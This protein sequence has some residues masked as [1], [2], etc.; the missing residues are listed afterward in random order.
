MK[1]SANVKRVLAY[2]CGVV[3]TA[4][5]MT[6]CLEGEP[7]A[8]TASTSEQNV[9]SATD[10]VGEDIPSDEKNPPIEVSEFCFDRESG[11]YDED[12]TLMIYH[13]DSDAKIYYTTDGSTPDEGDTLYDGKGIA[14]K[15]RTP[16]KNDLSAEKGISASGD[17]YVKGKVTKANVIRAVAI[18]PDG[19]K[20]E[21]INGTFFVGIDR[22]KEYGDVPVI[23]LLTDKENLFDYEKGIYVLGKTHDQWLAENSSNKW[24]DGWQQKGNYSNRGRDWERP[25]NV[26]YITAD[27]SEGFTQD[28]GVRIMGAASRNNNQ[29]SLRLVAREDYG[30]KNVKYPVIPENMMSDGSGEVTKY[31]SFVLR[32]GGNDCDFAKIRDPILQNLVSDRAFETMQFT[33]VV[34]FID[35][36]YW[37]MYSLVE[38]YNDNYIQNNY[39]GIDNENV[40]VIKN[41]GIEDG[42][43]D[44][45]KLFDDMYSYIANNDMSDGEKYSRA[46]EMLDMQ[47]FADYC[48]FNIYIYN[49]DSF[50]K[51]NNWSMWRVRDVDQSVPYADGKWRLM[52]FD[53]D[54]S[55]GIYSEGGNTNHNSIQDAINSGNNNNFPS[56]LFTSLLANGQFKGMFIN[57]MCDLRNVNFNPSVVSDAIDELRPVYEKLVPDTFRRFGP[58]WVAD[59]WSVEEYYS[60]KIDQFESFLVGRYRDFMPIIKNTFALEDA[61]EVTVK[62]DEKDGGVVINGVTDVD[63]GYDFEG[64]YFKEYPITIKAVCTDGKSFVRWE[65]EGCQVSDE[66]SAEAV[67]TIT[68]KCTIKAVFS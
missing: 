7:K 30:K 53:T 18:L 47:S 34:A 19:T 60:G 49:E 51:C 25:V 10:K 22:E 32:C 28:M 48:A 55:S 41:G 24:L 56:K 26:Q 16:E 58:Q 33:P 59:Q 23:S 27:G 17:Y 64:R 35:G 54:Y 1:G 8:T 11:F 38:D 43:E 62:T 40:V 46:C 50:F 37:G 21:V 4:S 14:L 65:C 12:F 20:S 61:C 45:K 9:T 31:K 39:E 5:V 66:S 36:E 42:L 57:A 52:A 15:D 67:F 13:P 3:L 6:S 44:D 63:L 2:I 29:K 68:G